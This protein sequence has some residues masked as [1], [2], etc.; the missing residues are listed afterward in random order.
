MRKPSLTLIGLLLI[1][2]AM[3]SCNL[4]RAEES[5]PT[6]EGNTVL[7]LAA[8]TAIAQLTLNAL[9]SPG[10]TNTTFIIPTSPPTDT[11]EPTEEEIP[12]DRAL[13][14][15]DVTV[16]DGS[17]F[18]PGESFEKVWRIQNT[19][20]CT[21]SDSYEL[22]FESGQD[23]G[24][25]DG[26]SLSGDVP[27]G[28]EVDISIDL[29]APS[30]AGSYK[31]IWQLRNA[32]GVIF[33]YGGLWVDIL[34]TDNTPEAY[35]AKASLSIEQTAFAELDEGITSGNT[36]DSDF[37]FD[38]LAD[39]DKFLAPR[40]GAIFTYIGEE[41]PTYQQCANSIMSDGN[42]EISTGLVGK[43]LCYRT[44][45][46]RYGRMKVISLEPAEITETQILEISFT[47]WQIP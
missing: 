17:E 36:V 10:P 38:L 33:T 1:L 42:I 18:N 44:D 28:Y 29:T 43:W 16:E 19:G 24:G 21:W 35:T 30:T 31:G 22:V 9:A 4:P 11:P 47:T 7:T 45:L 23:L 6:P 8:E 12:C 2:L 15:T 32:D 40:N 39:D 46:D 37:Q 20:S 3:A 25:A 41:Q 14:I 5:T 13:F 26:V 34:V 27:P